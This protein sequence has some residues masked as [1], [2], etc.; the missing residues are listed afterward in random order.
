MLR[1][2]EAQPEMVRRW[3]IARL[4]QQGDAIAGSVAHIDTVVDRMRAPKICNHKCCT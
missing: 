3:M 4:K 1:A 2:T